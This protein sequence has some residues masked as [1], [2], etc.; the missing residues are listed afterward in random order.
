MKGPAGLERFAVPLGQPLVYLVDDEAAV[1][2]AL[3]LLLRTRRLVCESFASAES[4]EAMLN[5][6]QSG[7][8]DTWPTAPTC[9]VLDMRM[10]GMNGLALY[11]RLADRG[12]ASGCPVIF[13]SG[14]ADVTTAVHAVK[15]GA[16]DFVEKPFS[17][18]A[19]VDRIELALDRSAVAIRARRAT[20]LFEQRLADLSGRERDVMQLVADGLANKVIAQRLDISVRTVE[21]HR[22]RVF[23]KMQVHSAIELVNS[24]RAR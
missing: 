7:S 6:V 3:A 8:L 1:R 10:S 20:R 23:E 4:F 12:L 5:V 9:L 24:L 19:L 18:N 14:H 2:D 16:F 13:L 21:V 17:N 22:A 15:R 11:E